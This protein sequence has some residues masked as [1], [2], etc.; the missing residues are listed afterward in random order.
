MEENLTQNVVACENC[1]SQVAD[2]KYCPTC[3]FPMGGTD[4]DKTQFRSAVSRRKRLL[5]DSQEK[6]KTARN[7]IYALAAFTFVIGLFVGLSTEDYLGMIL[8][9]ILCVLF[10]I[11][12]A[13]SNTNAFGAILTAFILYIT[14]NVINAFF[15]PTTLF[16][17]IILK[18]IF[19]GGF[20]KGIRS[21][22]EARDHMA[23]LEKVKAAPIGT[24]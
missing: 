14:L 3:S 9:L 4:E 13:W 7:I 16:Q 8:N 11:L 22:Q 20:I 1:S 18:I 24:H 17:G 23:E 5:N 6:T 10:L 15:D 2:R 19:I 12:A 21:A